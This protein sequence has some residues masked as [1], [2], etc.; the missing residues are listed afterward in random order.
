MQTILADAVDGRL[1]RFLFACTDPLQTDQEFSSPQ[2]VSQ[3]CYLV[4]LPW[5]GLFTRKVYLQIL[6]QWEVEHEKANV[7]TV[8]KIGKHK[9]R[10]FPRIRVVS[11]RFS[12]ATQPEEENEFN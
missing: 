6:F 8:F 9:A 3:A 4:K 11:E 1:E 2:Q 7:L 5:Y 10:L 12:P